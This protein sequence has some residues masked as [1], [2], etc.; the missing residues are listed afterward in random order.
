MAT[1]GN[2]IAPGNAMTLTNSVVNRL[3]VAF[4]FDQ[5]RN[6]TEAIAV[7][8]LLKPDVNLLCKATSRLADQAD[9][10]ANNH[11]RL[12]NQIEILVGDIGIQE[13]KFRQ[14]IE[15]AQHQMASN[16]AR[17]ND[18]LAH[19]NDIT[20][21]MDNLNREVRE[22][23]GRLEEA[24]KWC[25]VPGY[26]QYLAG[27]TL[28][29]LVDGKIGK[30]LNSEEEF[31]RL[32][33]DKN[34]SVDN[35]NKAKDALEKL[36][37]SVASN[38]KLENELKRQSLEL[39]AKNKVLALYKVFAME[40]KLYYSLV[41]VSLENIEQNNR[42]VKAAASRLS[43]TVETYD[44]S[45]KRVR[46]TMKEALL[47]VGRALDEYRAAN[48]DNVH[49]VS[50]GDNGVLLGTF[51]NNAANAWIETK[52]DDS[53]L[54]FTFTETQRDEW[55]VYLFDKSRGLTL[56]LDLWTNK[57][58]FSDKTR[59]KA[60]LYTIMDV[61]DKIPAWK[62]VTVEYKN[63]NDNGTFT[64]VLNKEWV[65]TVNLKTIFRFTETHRDDWSIFLVGKGRDC[66]IQ[67]DLWPNKIHYRDP[68]NDFD[69]YT[70]CG[71]A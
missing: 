67:L 37:D 32:V 14:L 8:T 40:V 26:G 3:M 17:Y 4:D 20:K 30:L 23:R 53:K 39:Q 34:T 70:I 7:L 38:S 18:I 63:G 35:L 10:S 68:N 2:I 27:R 65:E 12:T 57:I 22:I 36:N 19:C 62:A 64:A 13:Q 55:S 48:G 1:T 29:D 46:V 6:R 47:Q 45:G 58:Y 5:Q 61:S 54:R 60:E 42:N 50:Y 31:K 52:A 59:V 43:E 28:V 33:T 25:W 15:D 11:Q 56:H 41:S 21:E 44:K 24:A 69:L 49:L 71:V 51:F 16:T 66:K 9:A